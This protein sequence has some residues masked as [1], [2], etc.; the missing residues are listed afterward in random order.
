MVELF[1]EAMYIEEDIL[2]EMAIINP[3]LCDNRTIQIEVEQRNEG[4]IPHMH[5]YH[6]KNRNPKE[7][8][9]IRLDKVAYSEHHRDNKELPRKLKKQFVEIMNK[10]C[11]N[12]Y[13]KAKDGSVVQASGY[14]AAVIFWAQSFEKNSYNKFDLDE[15]GLIKQ[16]DYSKL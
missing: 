13:M 6:N 11:P 14:Q 12:I 2:C 7:C 15:N 10:D 1:K 16:L 8:S 9:Y 4:P 3:E 5:V